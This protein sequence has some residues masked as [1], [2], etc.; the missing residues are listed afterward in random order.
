MSPREAGLEICRRVASHTKRP[1]LLDEQGRPNFGLKFYLLDKT[2]Q[3]A[4]VSLW[5]PAKFAVTDKQGTRLEPCA[6]L[7]E[8][9]K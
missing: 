1:E 4:G 7:Y 8:T 6:Y 2:G 3:H 9:P 5:G